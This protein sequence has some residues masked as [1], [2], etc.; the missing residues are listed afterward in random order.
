MNDRCSAT[1]A[2]SNF[3]KLQELGIDAVFGIPCS[4]G[5]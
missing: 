2:I 4:T 1:V 5:M 3:M